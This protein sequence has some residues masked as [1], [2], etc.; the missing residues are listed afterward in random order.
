[1][2]SIGDWTFYNCS[3]LISVNI[4][5]SVTTIGDYAFSMCSGLTSVNIPNSVTA[6]G[7]YAF[8]NSKLK[9]VTIRSGVL[10]IGSNAFSQPT[11]VI[12]LTNTPPSGYKNAAGT[13]NYVA[14][15]LYSDLNNK[16]VYPFL[17]SLFEVDGMK[18]VPVSPSERTC[19]AIDCAYNPSIETINIGKEVMFKGVAMTIKEVNQYVCY[20]NPFIKEVNLSFDANLESYTFKNCNNTTIVSINNKGAVGSEAF[21]GSGLTALEVGTNVTEIDSS[22]FENCANLMTAKLHNHGV[23]RSKAFYKSGLNALEVGTEITEIGSSAFM[24]CAKLKT[25]NLQNQGSIGTGAFQKCTTLKIVRIGE[26]NT[27]VGENAFSGCQSLQSIVIPNST[28]ELGIN[29]FKNCS[30]MT[31]AQIGNSVENIGNEAFSNCSSMTSAQIGNSVENIGN[32]AFLNCSALPYISIPQSVTKIGNYAFQGCKSIKIVSMAD[33]NDDVS[34]AL[35]SN[36][37]SPLFSSCPLD[38]VYIGRNITY[39]TSSSYGYSPFYRN[40]S[41]RSV[42]ITDKETEISPNE[43]YGCTNLKN[44]RIGNGVT[45]IGDWAFSGCSS[46][47]YFFFGTKVESIGKEAFSDCTAMTKLISRA[48]TPPT[49]GSQALDD[50]NKWS[51][52][53]QVPMESV[54]SYRTAAQWKEFFFVEQGPTGIHK[55]KVDAA[56]PVNIYNLNGMKA[57]GAHKG[58]NIIRM[59]DGTSKKVLEK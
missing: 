26:G 8:Y 18:Y 37:S 50:I 55:T 12:W 21:Y 15:G 57:T 24:N 33:R 4:P 20:G 39:S 48:N 10:S 47:D 1:M 17:S 30:S 28:K 2:T 41:L 19:D 45:T 58:L 40:T 36:G 49:C 25:A 29:S 56:S 52:V 23:I 44:V 46:L 22:A 11:K 42:T 9:S 14:N 51:C 35:G 16:K 53:L 59:S 34:L 31:S 7:D 27:E 6:I 3:G 5:N 13:V 54:D 43:F 32:G 38:S